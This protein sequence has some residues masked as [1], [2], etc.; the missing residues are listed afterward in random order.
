MRIIDAY[1][2]ILD[3]NVGTPLFSEVKMNFED[4]NT[5]NYLEKL[6]KKILSSTDMKLI[7][8]FTKK[9]ILINKIESNAELVELNSLFCNEYYDLIL[10]QI[11]ESCDMIA[12]H[13]EYID[14]EYYIFTKIKY[15]K[16]ITHSIKNESLRIIDLVQHNYILRNNQAALCDSFIYS[17]YDK[18][19]YVIDEYKDNVFSE[20]VINAKVLKSVKEKIKHLKTVTQDIVDEFYSGSVVKSLEINENISESLNETSSI[21]IETISIDCFKDNE[22]AKN[23]FLNKISINILENEVQVPESM[24][25]KYNKKQKIITDSGIEILVP[26]EYINDKSKIDIKTSEN[27]SLVITLKNIDK[28]IGK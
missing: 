17:L 1:L 21:N 24:V 23:T 8:D 12:L 22:S 27:G 19:F 6:A 9:N 18:K 26:M 10:K 14:K 20:K 4:I 13:V 2:S 25:K 15:T 3:E 5:F 7:G 11:S 16:A 28:I